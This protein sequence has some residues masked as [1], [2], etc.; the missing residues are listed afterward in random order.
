MTTKSDNMDNNFFNSARSWRI[1]SS[2]FFK[3]VRN[4]FTSFSARDFALI[5]SFNRVVNVEASM[6]VEGEAAAAAAAA[7]E[8]ADRGDRGE[9]CRR[10]PG[11]SPYWTCLECLLK[12]SF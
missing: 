10:R 11:K 6:A 1:S 7:V 2:L 8:A 4:R 12:P 5:S 9:C 3:R